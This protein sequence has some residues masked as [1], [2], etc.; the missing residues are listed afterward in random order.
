M[1]KDNLFAYIFAIIAIGMFLFGFIVGQIK[2][3]AD[4]VQ[5]EY[6]MD[7]INDTLVTIHSTYGGQY[8][9]SNI[10]EIESVLIKDNQ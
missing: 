1:K 2:Q 9:E 6:G 10:K 3:K 8:Y 5:Y 7:I 4:T